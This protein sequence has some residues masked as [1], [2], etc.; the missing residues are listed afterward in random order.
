M[1]NFL[2]RVIPQALRLPGWSP[3]QFQRP[4]VDR[5]DQTIPDLRRHKDHG[6]TERPFGCPEITEKRNTTEKNEINVRQVTE[7]I[8]RFQ[9]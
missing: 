6:T 5:G 4:A 3:D 8:K 1:R 7:G 2:A 9:I